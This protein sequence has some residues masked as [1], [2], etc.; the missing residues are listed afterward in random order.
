VRNMLVLLAM[1]AAALACCSDGGGGQQ[2]CSYESRH[3]ACGGSGWGNW[4]T[5]CYA[6][7]LDDYKEGWT[8]ERV[9]QKFSGSDSECS[10]T[11][12]I[13]VEYRNSTVGS[14]GC[15]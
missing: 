7:N 10:T 4:T 1:S 13:Y 8:A 2:H 3:T 9:C 15:P 5:E 14:G 6:F 12:C 11:C